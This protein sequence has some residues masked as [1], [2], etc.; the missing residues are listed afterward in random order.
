MLDYKSKQG[1]I[2]KK[3]IAY[4]LLSV[5]TIL[6][7]IL[8]VSGLSI[9]AGKAIP[10]NHPLIIGLV[11]FLIAI[12][13][14]PLRLWLEKSIE[15]VFPQSKKAFHGQIQAFSQEISQNTDVKSICSNLRKSVNDTLFPDLLHIF[16]ND[17]WSNH[18]LATID[19]SGLPTSDLRFP[20]SSP[21]VQFLEEKKSP[22]CFDSNH[23]TDSILD[24]DRSRMALLGAVL[25]V[26]LPGQKAL[27][28]WLA[29]GS[30][31]SGDSYQKAD[32]AY[33][34]SI[35]KEAASAIE[36]LQVISNL[37]RRVREMDVLTR[38]AQGVNITLDFDN[39]LELIYTQTNQVIPTLDFRI[40]LKNPAD[41]KYYH[42]FFL[43]NDERLAYNENIAIPA[44]QGLEG[45]VIQNQ[46]SLITLDYDLECRNH[47][48]IPNSPGVI[49]WLG[50]PL[51]A[52]S[53]TLGCISL[54]SRDPA[55]VFTEQQRDLLQAIADQAAGAIIKSQILSESER[56]ARQLATLNE[57]GR[58]LT[59][60]LELN[61]V[62][63]QIMNSAMELLNC[64]AGSLYIVEPQTNDITVEVTIGPGASDT[65]G[66]RLPPGSGVVS[67]VIE[68]G[69]PVIVNSN[70]NI[71]DWAD[72]SDPESGFYQRDL[73]AVQMKVKQTVLGVIE[74][75]N[76]LDET[77]FN[78]DD[79]DIL[80][81]FASQAAVAIENAR[82][83]TQ[84]DK[85]LSSRL[86]EMS[87]MQRIDREL[88]TSL[89]VERAMRITLEWSMNQS[90]SEAGLIGFVDKDEQTPC[91]AVRVIASRGIDNEVS[92]QDGQNSPNIRELPAIQKV[93]Q[94]GQPVRSIFESDGHSAHK[95]DDSDDTYI[96][97][98]VISSK[99]TSE[100]K[101][102][103]IIPIRR[104]TEVIG[105]LLLESVNKDGYSSDSNLFLTRLCDHA[106][107]AISNAQLYEDL[108][109][110]NIAKSEF[111]SLVSH[112][113]K[114]PMTSI[115]GYADLLAQGT[116]GPI[117]EIQ[118]NFINTIRSN[119]NRMSN[120]VSDLADVSR[121][122]AG[123]MR[124]DFERYPSA[125]LSKKLLILPGH[126]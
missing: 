56:R 64:E 44:R 35:C 37:E 34:E 97:N 19:E 88:N 117:N 95:K 12:S 96:T 14:N 55:T 61:A 11:I 104:K 48:V 85:A 123:K 13:I 39:I 121:I 53:Q 54:G 57:V 17:P 28:G 120:L 102:Q 42:T 27:V 68:S 59:S 110:A 92:N 6:A 65:T 1:I 84:T 122:E 119:V 98:E 114:T 126:C 63:K 72:H 49:A 33:L 99:L 80:S 79:Q 75:I 23:S 30:R 105:I 21:L 74:I 91:A 69:H 124:L 40:T 36:R 51:H 101:S 93:I 15:R 71:Q 66:T 58:T 20:A 83:Y 86:E 100:A 62:L 22:Y 8:L 50:V 77:P 103:I 3:T 52:G 4:A 18:Y 109:A 125:R 67:K 111:V 5:L 116:V 106:A 87:V 41:G 45:V 108:Q 112:E 7:Y 90:K 31:Q 24:K 118:G 113:L 43:E 76:K 16:I 60:T 2:F 29:V 115:R 107:I 70:T 38:I 47:G 82:L 9:L 73:L 32:V 10:I 25:Y 89:D 46:K 81:T 94:E 26:P 78:Q